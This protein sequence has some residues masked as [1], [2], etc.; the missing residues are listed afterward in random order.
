MATLKKECVLSI[1]VHGHTS[2]YNDDELCLVMEKI[3]RTF[4]SQAY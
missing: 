3:L 2:D 1:T 4:R